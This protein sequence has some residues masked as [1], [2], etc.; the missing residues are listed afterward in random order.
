MTQVRQIMLIPQDRYWDWV[1]AAREYVLHYSITIT[2]DPDSAGRFYGQDHT[3]TLINFPAAWPQ[4]IVAWFRRNYPALALDVIEVDASRP[5]RLRELLAERVAN[6]DRF[7]RLQRGFKLAW[8]TEYPVMTQPFGANPQYY[9]RFGLPGH[10]GVDIRAPMNSPVYACAAGRVYLIHDGRGNHPYGIHVRIQH[11]RAAGSNLPFRTV[12]AHLSRALVSED[13]IVQ[14]GQRIGLADS[15]G[16]SDASHLHLTLKKDGATERGETI[17]PHDIIDPTFYLQLP[18]EGTSAPWRGSAGPAA[19][20]WEPGKC[21][22]GV[23]GRADGPLQNPD[24]PAV[25]TARVEAVKLI[26]N[27]APEDVDRI[28]AINP[29]AFILA[30][31]F[32]DF[33]NGRVVQAD[34]FARWQEHDMQRLY[35]KGVRYFE[36]HNEPNLVLEGLGASWRDGNE[37][38]TW[39]LRVVEHLRPRFPQAKFGFPG[40]SPGGSMPGKR[41]DMW[42]FVCQCEQAIEAADWIGVHCYWLDE[43][44]MSAADDGMGLLAFQRYW[45][46]KLVFVTEFSNPSTTVSMQEKGQQYLRYYHTLRNLPGVGAAF[47][48]VL[49]ASADFPHEAWRREDG[50]MTVIPAIVGNRDF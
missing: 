29:N 24:Y 44:G 14:T 41:A 1:Q 18:G 16:N 15:T 7:G 23:H 39:F 11:S 33:R 26:V 3:V 25:Q 40:C 21:L 9:R 5:D 22:V 10:E 35:D 27:A 49:S 43:D 20:E 31:L 17:F 32:A 47:S 36:V 42:R 30:R 46:H 34:E 6:D 37:F 12:Y 28:R 50:Q 19:P 48:F 2:P 38:E 45:P 8:P 13:E 4:D